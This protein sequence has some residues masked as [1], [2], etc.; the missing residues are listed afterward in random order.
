M[1]QD[2]PSSEGRKRQRPQ[3]VVRFLVRVTGERPW[4][5]EPGREAML[6]IERTLRKL[7]VENRLEL[8]LSHIRTPKQAITGIDLFEVELEAPKDGVRAYR[9]G[10]LQEENPFKW[11]TPAYAAWRRNYDE[12][13]IWSVRD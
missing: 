5:W 13:K 11:G 1:S 4:R 9:E 8:D 2:Q 6:L 3:N 10:F 7:L 12:A